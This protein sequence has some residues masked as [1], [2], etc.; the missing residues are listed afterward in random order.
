MHDIELYQEMAH[1]REIS[2]MSL[3]QI[4]YGFDAQICSSSFI[5]VERIFDGHF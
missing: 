2:Q 1:G 5:H 4:I 3:F